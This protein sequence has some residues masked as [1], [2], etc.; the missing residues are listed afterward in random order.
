VR[1]AT[2]VSCHKQIHKIFLQPIASTAVAALFKKKFGLATSG[3]GPDWFVQ[4][5]SCAGKKMQPFM[6]E[7]GPWDM[8]DNVFAVI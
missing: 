5:K 6:T 7:S 1:T 4:L 8:Y 3:A 2:F